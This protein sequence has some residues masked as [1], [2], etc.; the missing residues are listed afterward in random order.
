MQPGQAPVELLAQELL[1]RCRGRRHIGQELVDQFV[2]VRAHGAPYS[3]PA[4]VESLQPC[5][6]PGGRAP[7]TRGA[8]GPRMT[9]SVTMPDGRE[10]AYEEYG[11]PGGFPS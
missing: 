3:V 5:V 11:D 6:A 8:G 9:G 7:W 2:Y 4:C 1:G 10:L